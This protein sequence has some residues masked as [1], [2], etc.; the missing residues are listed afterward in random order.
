MVGTWHRTL[1][2]EHRNT[3][4]ATDEL[5]NDLLEQ[6]RYREAEALFLS[7]LER[8]EA[9]PF[10]LI[11]RDAVDRYARFLRD[12]GRDDEAAPFEDRLASGPLAAAA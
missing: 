12:R 10:R 6:G 1:G 7:A 5:G 4:E 8:A 9:G 11:E 3:L 2:A